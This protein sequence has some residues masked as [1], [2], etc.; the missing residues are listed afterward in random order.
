M[1][2]KSIN[3]RRLVPDICLGLVCTHWKTMRPVNTSI[4]CFNF[5][6]G[7]GQKS[8]L[9]SEDGKILLCVLYMQG[10]KKKI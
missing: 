9:V 1:I 6:N 8:S 4:I 2:I 3:E 10:S 7:E 5:L